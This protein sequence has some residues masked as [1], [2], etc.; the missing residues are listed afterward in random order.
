MATKKNTA[1]KRGP[2]P[3]VLKIDGDWVEAIGKA[4]KAGKPKPK[5]RRAVAYAHS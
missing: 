5:K 2:K 3:Q 4:M 1:A